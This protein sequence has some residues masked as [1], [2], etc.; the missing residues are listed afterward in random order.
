VI[1]S[2]AASGTERRMAFVFRELSRRFPGV[3]LLVLSGDLL[4]ALKEGG[5]DLV[6]RPD[7]KALTGRSSLDKKRGAEDGLLRNAGRV[8]T[9]LQYRRELVKILQQESVD[10]VHSYLEMVPFLGWFPLPGVEMMASL[11]SHLP[12]YYDRRNPNCRL[13]L[14]ALRGYAKV[15]A[16]YSFIVDRLVALGVAPAKISFPT[17]NCVDT[18][19]FHPRP[20]E[21][22]VTFTGRAYAF[23]NPVLMLDV[24]EHVGS[25]HTDVRFFVLGEGPLL[26]TL[27]RKA[28]ASRLAARIEV[29]HFPDPSVIVNRSAVHVCL[30]EYDN[31]TNQSLLE[32][33]AAG[34]AV[35]ASDVGLTASVIR[36]GNGVLVPLEPGPIVEAVSGLLR[37]KDRAEQM[38]SAARR[39][40]LEEHDVWTYIEYL[41]AVQGFPP[42]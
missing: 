23:K 5:F 3:Y 29:D 34:C 21:R 42:D 33:M 28:R 15:D 41:R 36:G 18:E 35:V 2:T 12:K 9:L 32:G 24:I 30:E 37:D 10:L 27:R 11:V 4:R 38:G 13:L 14:G 40:C 17:R 25:A 39:T 6:G 22:I 31:A 7:V 1:V 19:R 8:V 20:K 26:E 16:L